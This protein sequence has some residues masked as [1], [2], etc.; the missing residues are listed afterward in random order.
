MAMKVEPV[1]EPFLRSVFA[2]PFAM[3]GLIP[4]PWNIEDIVPEFGWFLLIIVKKLL[5]FRSERQYVMA[6]LYREGFHG[7][8]W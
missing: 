6:C 7:E 5:L 1:F 2:N 3:A 8:T 4:C